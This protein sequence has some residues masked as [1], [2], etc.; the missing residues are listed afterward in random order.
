[1]WDC[2]LNVYTTWCNIPRSPNAQTV[3]CWFVWMIDFL[4]C[5]DEAYYLQRH[6]MTKSVGAFPRHWMETVKISKYV[7]HTKNLPPDHFHGHFQDKG[8]MVLWSFGVSKVSIEDDEDGWYSCSV[9]P[10]V[11]SISFHKSHSHTWGPSLLLRVIHKHVR[12][13]SGLL[14]LEAEP[15]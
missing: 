2:K 9:E 7:F 4:I 8:F 14:L 12:A 15:K 6:Q 3:R 5:D 10:A 13:S 11:L 1:M